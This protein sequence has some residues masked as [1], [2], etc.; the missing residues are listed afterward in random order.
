[1]YDICISMKC[2]KCTQEIPNRAIIDGKQRNLSKRKY[3]LTCSP[4]GTHNTRKIFDV[5]KGQKN[6]NIC[7]KPLPSRRRNICNSCHVTKYRQN[8]KKKLVEYK[9]GKCHICGYNRCFRNLTFHHIDSDGKE[10]T[11]SSKTCSFEN[12]KQEVD[13]CVLLCCLCHGELHDGLIKL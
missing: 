7:H 6:C 1:M 9:G 12:L 2:L 8:I 3:C 13:K 5:Y 11:I 4:F 10:F